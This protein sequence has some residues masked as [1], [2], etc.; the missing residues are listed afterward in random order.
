MTP[1]PPAGAAPQFAE[2]PCFYVAQIVLTALQVLTRVPVNIAGDSDFLLTGIHGTSTGDFTINFRLPGGGA[3]ANA[4]VHKANIIGAA[5]QPT[6]IGPPAAY[7]AGSSGPLLDLTD[8][9]NAGNTLELI[10][11]GIKR[12]R[13]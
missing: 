11:S 6:P 9:S 12:T 3:F 2:E 4:Q 5:N 7:R 1:Q 13:V 10:F 8:V